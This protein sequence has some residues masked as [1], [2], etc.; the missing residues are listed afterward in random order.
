MKS[1]KT[2]LLWLLLIP[3]IWPASAQEFPPPPDPPR[4]VNDYF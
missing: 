3:V 2:I 1:I 4:L